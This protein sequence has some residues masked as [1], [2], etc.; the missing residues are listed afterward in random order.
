MTFQ[1]ADPENPFVVA[2]DTRGL[3][4]GILAEVAKRKHAHISGEFVE[5]TPRPTKRRRTDAL[6]KSPWAFSTGSFSSPGLSSMTKSSAHTA[7]S[8][9]ATAST[10]MLVKG[11]RYALPPPT[12]SALLASVDEHGIPSKVYT[13]PYYSKASD[14][15][16]RPREY[17]GLVFHLKG[18]T[19]LDTLEEWAGSTPD[20]IG[21]VGK[22]K[23]RLD[24]TGVTGWEYAS[25]PPSAREVRRWLSSPQGRKPIAPD[26]PKRPSQVCLGLLW[27]SY[28][29]EIGRA[30]V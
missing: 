20:S 3:D 4:K 23:R 13:S 19:G 25:T 26:R 18:G 27:F 2:E 7:T 12:A 15:P 11:Y 1:E 8:S 6:P 16:E 10:G 14:A 22:G 29:G 24:P 21:H 30:H 28:I 5:M 17:A 9:K